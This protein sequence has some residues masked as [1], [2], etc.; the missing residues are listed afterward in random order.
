MIR[1]YPVVV[2]TSNGECCI[3]YEEVK[4]LF[5]GDWEYWGDL[6][7]KTDEASIATHG[8][9]ALIY[10]P[11]TIKY[12]FYSNSNMIIY[13]IMPTNETPKFFF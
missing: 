4:Q 6:R 2:G 8:N 1:C 5:L 3:N 9:T 7:I 10:V 11:G 12:T 13:T